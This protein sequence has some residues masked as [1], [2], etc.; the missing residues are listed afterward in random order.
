MAL[1]FEF[2]VAGPPVSQQASSRSR[3]RWARV[4]RDAVE[5]QWGQEPAETGMVAVTIT[6]F[7]LKDALDVDNIPKPIL[8]ALNRLVYVDDLQVTDLL[9]RKR[10]LNRGPELPEIPPAQRGYRSAR[11]PFL[12]IAVTH[13]SDQEVTL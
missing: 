10:N 8:D 1:P 7:F 2:F 13:A 4:V 9:C 11:R 3:R 5:S 6:Y 12:Q